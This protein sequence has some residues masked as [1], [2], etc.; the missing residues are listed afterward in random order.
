MPATPPNPG[1]AGPSTW[2]EKDPMD[3]DTTP[4]QRKPRT[5]KAGRSRKPVTRPR[6]AGIPADDSDDDPDSSPTYRSRRGRPV[7]YRPR[8]GAMFMR[9]PPSL[10]SYAGG[11]APGIIATPGQATSIRRPQTPEAQVGASGNKRRAVDD[12]PTAPRATRRR[13]DGAGNI[14]PGYD[15]ADSPDQGSPTKFIFDEDIDDERE[16]SDYEPDSPSPTTTRAQ[17]RILRP[18][19]TR[20]TAGI[21]DR[22]ALLAQA[23]EERKKI[24]ELTSAFGGM[25]VNRMD[26]DWD[27]ETSARPDPPRLAIPRPNIDWDAPLE[28]E[29]MVVD[30]PPPTAKMMTLW[31]KLKGKKRGQEKDEEED[32]DDD[33][34]D[35][36]DYDDDEMSLIGLEEEIQRFKQGAGTRKPLAGGKAYRP[37]RPLVD[38][39]IDRH[40]PNVKRVK[41]G[42][43]LRE[44]DS[45]PDSSPSIRSTGHTLRRVAGHDNLAESMRR[46]PSYQYKL[47]DPKFTSRQRQSFH[48]EED[49]ATGVSNLYYDKPSLK[50]TGHVKRI[51]CGSGHI[52]NGRFRKRGGENF[53]MAFP[54]DIRFLIYQHLLTFD[55]R[56]I[57]VGTGAPLI[58]VG[59]DI[60][61]CDNMIMLTSRTIYLEAF[62]V[63][64]GINTFEIKVNWEHFFDPL[65]FLPADFGLAVRKINFVHDFKIN[66]NL[67]EVLAKMKDIPCYHYPNG[68]STRLLDFNAWAPILQRLDY[69]HIEWKVETWVRHR[70]YNGADLEKQNLTKKDGWDGWD[71]IWFA[72]QVYKATQKAGSQRTSSYFCYWDSWMDPRFG[73]DLGAY[74]ECGVRCKYMEDFFAKLWETDVGADF[75]V[76]D[77]TIEDPDPEFGGSRS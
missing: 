32:D 13:T 23:R 50:R 14:V 62:R 30:P 54:Y 77:Y 66:P 34:D 56:L 60:P 31:K 74:H 70:L 20:N 28:E 72:M 4:E 57:K 75:D 26:L 53:I 7:Q 65:H 69:C 44:E 19:G 2:R 52:F 67:R 33:D 41:D 17:R 3:I 18:T 27:P 36:D 12:A 76:S 61:R 16:D 25:N 64:Y 58:T 49:N 24:G 48:I 6:P 37:Y 35:D 45:L 47:A 5:S 1:T 40:S 51:K 55:A 59:L 8:G 71:G 46:A 22:Q 10:A 39:G 63:F 29:P 15:D 68:P 11:V 73:M 43:G 42:A 9:K 38:K 21:L